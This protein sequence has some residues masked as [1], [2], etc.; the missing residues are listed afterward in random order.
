MAE[1]Q[2]MA[3]ALQPSKGDPNAE[4]TV[5]QIITACASSP[6]MLAAIPSQHP[7]K[8][9]TVEDAMKK[10]GI[11][12]DWIKSKGMKRK[13]AI[14]LYWKLHRQQKEL[15]KVDD[16]LDVP[17][18]QHAS[19][20]LQITMKLMMQTQMLL[21]AQNWVAASV[22][23]AKA[24][25][26]FANQLWSHDDKEAVEMMSDVLK[27]EGLRA[28]KLRLEPK[29]EP[30]EM[31]QGASFDVKVKLHRD[32][33]GYDGPKPPEPADPSG[34]YE[35]Y[36]LYVIAVG[37]KKEDPNTFVGVQPIQ[38]KKLEDKVIET[39]VKLTAPPK[40]GTQKLKVVICSTSTIGVHME[41]A[42]E[43]KVTD[44]VATPAP[45]DAA[46]KAVSNLS[47]SDDG[48]MDEMGIKL[49]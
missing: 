13:N 24:S 9:E 6:G 30:A 11:K 17:T 32:H 35:A 20:C 48:G 18:Q 8:T 33:H 21:P 14:L 1:M 26:L 19:A 2:H 39:D 16:D 10:A 12:L 15:K 41:E 36:W 44:E 45:E 40:A 31:A 4:V 49:K 47:V 37:D 3:M 27:G 23:I 22:G 34:T 46:A 42:L 38:C 43:F 7:S 29:V 28:P 25:A 5:Q